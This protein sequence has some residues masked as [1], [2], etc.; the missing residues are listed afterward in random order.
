MVSI[1]AAPM[2]ISINSAQCFLFSNPHQHLL[3]LV[4]ASHSA[5]CEVIDTHHCRFHLYVPDG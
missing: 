4:D 2:H 5:R 1:V 3:S